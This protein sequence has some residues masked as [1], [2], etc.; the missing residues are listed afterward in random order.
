MTKKPLNRNFCFVLNRYHPQEPAKDQI[1]EKWKEF[2]S[3]KINSEKYI[4]NY[5][6]Y[7]T[8]KKKELF[9]SSN[10]RRSNYYKQH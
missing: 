8:L 10:L 5:T 9:E 6:I 4:V 3:K 2:K 7:L 1:D